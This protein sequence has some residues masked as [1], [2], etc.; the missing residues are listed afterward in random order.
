MR[1]KAILV[2]ST[3]FSSSET[4]PLNSVINCGILSRGKLF[5]FGAPTDWLIACCSCWCKRKG[6]SVPLCLDCC[7]HLVCLVQLLKNFSAVHGTR[8]FVTVFT[9]ALHWSLPWA[10]SIQSIPPHPN[11]LRSILLLSTHLRLGLP[12][13]FFFLTFPPISFTHSTF[14]SFVLHP[15]LISSSLTWSFWVYLTR[16]TSYKISHY[17]KEI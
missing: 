4:A 17:T 2:L 11:C 13:G 5:A 3:V 7:C 6:R 12:S 8:S 9:A 16:S 1:F 14:P 10:R 15:M